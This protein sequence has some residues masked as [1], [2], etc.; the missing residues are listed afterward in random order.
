MLHVALGWFSL[1]VR[2][3]SSV[4]YPTHMVSRGL[5]CSGEDGSSLQRAHTL[6]RVRF[7]HA[8]LWFGLHGQHFSQGCRPSL[9]RRCPS[10]FFCITYNFYT[11]RFVS[12][13]LPLLVTTI[14]QHPSV[15]FEDGLIQPL[16]TSVG[17]L[18]FCCPINQGLGRCVSE[19]EEDKTRTHRCKVVIE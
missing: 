1:R 16:S 11:L 6:L 14:T 15:A 17:P 8:P 7:S 12:R 13:R 4:F 2:L 5:L 9:C 18:C 3:D 10:L 19:G